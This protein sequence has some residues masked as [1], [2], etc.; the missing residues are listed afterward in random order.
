MRDL[1]DAS[2]VRILPCNEQR[3]VWPNNGLKS[4]ALRSAEPRA[5][6]LWQNHGE[7]IANLYDW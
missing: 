5:D 3:A 4:A 7:A 6:F 1:N 2:M